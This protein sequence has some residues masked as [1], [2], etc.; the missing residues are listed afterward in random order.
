MSIF[1]RKEQHR[2]NLFLKDLHLK[3]KTKHLKQ[4]EGNQIPFTL[5]IDRFKTYFPCAWE[6]IVSYCRDKKSDYYRRKRKGLRAVPFYTPEAFLKKHAHMGKALKYHL[7]DEEKSALRKKILKKARNQ[8][9]AR[10]KFLA[11]NLV[12]VQE[13][14]PPYIKDLIKSYFNI[15]RTKTL[16]INA[17]YLIL[18]EAS[19]FKCDETIGFLHKISAC[20]K[21]YDL[22][23][24]AYHALRRMGEHPWLARNRKG[25]KYLS[26]IKQIDVKENPTELLHLLYE[27]Q[28]AV[29][30]S[31]DVF[32]SHSSLDT[33]E[34]L[35]LKS[36]LNRQGKTVYIDWI[37]D[38]VMLNRTNQN[39]DTWNA[40]ELRM[41]QSKVLLYVMTDNSIRSPYTQK[42]VE[43]FKKTNKPI[44]V[45]QPHPISLPIPEYLADCEMIDIV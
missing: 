15:R 17:R 25:K 23:I 29:Y 36:K 43:Y 14:C 11:D 1:Y 10:E 12:Y 42:E 38:R 44:N 16:N 30:Q 41:D 26:Q 20:D 33:N 21:N 39:E 22:R 45:Y 18:L 6:D 37:N 34:L 13:V 35:N 8:K 4:I 7:T 24:M 9:K 19:Q 27:N 32:L 5:Y 40:L 3:V 2:E 28:Q 31:F